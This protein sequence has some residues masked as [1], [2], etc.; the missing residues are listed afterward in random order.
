MGVYE[1]GKKVAARLIAQYVK[2]MKNAEVQTPSLQD[3][4]QDLEDKVEQL[5]TKLDEQSIE[6]ENSL[7]ESYKLSDRLRAIGDEKRQIKASLSSATQDYDELMKTT[8]ELKK[9]V[10]KS[11]MEIQQYRDYSLRQSKKAEDALA[12]LR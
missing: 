1:S 7:E 12:K 8:S 2:P 9:I 3:L 6:L 10:G 5:Q 4:L 11:D